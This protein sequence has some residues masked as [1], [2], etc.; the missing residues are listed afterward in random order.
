[1]ASQSFAQELVNITVAG[2]LYNTYTTA[3]SVLT[4]LTSTAAST[5]LITLAPNFFQLGA[6]LEIDFVAGISN[7]VTGPDTFTVQVM[8]GSVI[9][10]TTGAIN[11]T[12]TAHTTIPCKCHIDLSVRSVGNGTL[13]TLEGQAEFT[14]QMVAMAASLADNAGGTGYAMGPNTAP[15]VGTGFDST[16]ANTLDLWVAQ[17]VSNAGNGFQLRQYSVKS[18]GNSAA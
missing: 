10:F 15:A 16:I 8:V 18:W 11:L 13:A 6:R 1:M 9:A 5:G 7:R 17:S 14:G 3:K 4:S 12:T 2:T